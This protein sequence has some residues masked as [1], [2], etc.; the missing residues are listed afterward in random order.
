LVLDE[1]KKIKFRRKG[2]DNNGKLETVM[3]IKK[4]E[5]VLLLDK[6]GDFTQFLF[7]FVSQL[8]TN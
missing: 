8:R 2:I 3:P 6:Q 5:S 7:N 4:S 1:E